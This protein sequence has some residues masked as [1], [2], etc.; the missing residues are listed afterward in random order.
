MTPRCDRKPHGG[1]LVT[2]LRFVHSLVIC[3]ISEMT[4][5]QAPLVQDALHRARSMVAQASRLLSRDGT[6]EEPESEF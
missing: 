6:H 3:Y 4:C 2:H 1:A 5:A